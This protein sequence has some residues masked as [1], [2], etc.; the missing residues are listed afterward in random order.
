MPSSTPLSSAER[1]RAY[2]R[3]IRAAGGEG[4]LLGLPSE[5]VTLLVEQG[6]PR[7]VQPQTDAQP[8][9]GAVATDRTEEGNRPAH[10]LNMR[11]PTLPGGLCELATGLTASVWRTL[12][13]PS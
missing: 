10:D 2:R 13:P 3:G 8:Q 9:A 11:K 12:H 6:A 5:V 4:M 7:L 1:A